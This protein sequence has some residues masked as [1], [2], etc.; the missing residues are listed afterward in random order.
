MMTIL[1]SKKLSTISISTNI[2]KNDIEYNLI[3]QHLHNRCGVHTLTHQ[4]NSFILIVICSFIKQS[5]PYTQEDYLKSFC[6]S[7]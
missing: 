4:K 3:Y 6:K 2:V 5:K 1:I 7:I